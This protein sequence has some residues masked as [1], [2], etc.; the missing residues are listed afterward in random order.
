[1]QSQTFKLVKRL[2][3]NEY[4]KPFELTPGQ[5]DIFNAVAMR[6]WPRTQVVTYTQYGKSDAISM[7]MLTRTTNY[8]EKWT[9]VA[10]SDKKT[11]IIMGYL[12]GHIF[13]NPSTAAKFEIEK[14]E[15][16]DR[17]RRERSKNHL[18]FKHDRGIGEVMA[19][20]AEGK[21]T[22]DI[23]NATL[24]F[25][26]RNVIIDESPTLTEEHYAGILR[27]LG[28]HKDNLLV[29]IGNA[30][31]RAHFFKASRDPTYHHIKVDYLQGIKE[32]RQSAGFF[33]EMKRKI[34]ADLF[35]MLYECKFPDEA[36]I[37]R[38]GYSPLLTEKDLDRAYVETVPIVGQKRYGIDVAGGGRNYSTVVKRGDNAAK[39]L[40]REQIAD[41]MSFVGFAVS[42]IKND[43]S[44]RGDL[45]FVDVVGIGKGVYDRIKETSAKELPGVEVIGVNFG[46][47]PDGGDDSDFL[48][49]RAQSFWRAGEW[50]NAGGKLIVNQGW[51]ELLAIRW[52]YQSEKKI[53]IKSK[54]DMLKEG[55]E[56]PD[57]ADGFAMTFA[58]RKDPV[59]KFKQIDTPPISEYET[60]AEP[61]SLYQPRQKVY[62]QDEADFVSEFEDRGNGGPKEWSLDDAMK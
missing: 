44:R 29:E 34:R 40:F 3:K 30:I 24:G 37:D 62:R 11:K 42:L 58:R 41:T 46:M 7:G 43:G 33:D 39:V 16:I 19:I 38:D 50:V 61:R 59:I 48:N 2:F 25:G 22:K 21:R 15:S 60:G 27:M 13:D 51:E 4:G 49:L 28:G 18:T 35:K 36:A 10:P 31:D 26:S 17:I 56:S 55:V 9:I 14:G 8:P 1:M 5:E 52:K 47:S 54:E 12:I 53:K 23:I 6:A 57:I 32:G 20:S 45:I